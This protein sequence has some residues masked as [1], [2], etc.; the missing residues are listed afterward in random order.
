MLM[1]KCLL[2]LLGFF[3]VV[4]SFGQEDTT[5]KPA[6]ASLAYFQVQ[7]V[8]NVVQLKWS[9]DQSDEL[10]SFDIERSE[11][12]LHFIKIGSRLAISKSENEDYDFVDATPGKNSSLYYRLKLISKDGFASYSGLKE[13]KRSAEKLSLR[14]LQNPVRS[15]IDFEVNALAVKQVSVAVVSHGGL[16]MVSQTFSLLSGRNQYSLSAQ[17]LPQGIYR[18]VVDAGT[19]RKTISFVKE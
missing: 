5:G 10:K 19:E 14:L 15:T 13:I 8:D 17:T 3:L 18:L 7:A 12:S 2:I 11:D 6:F 9:S 16:Q 1:K 4:K